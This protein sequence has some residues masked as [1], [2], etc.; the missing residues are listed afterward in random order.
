MLKKTISLILT[1]A[2]LISLLPSFP[3][4]TA[5]AATDFGQMNALDALGIDTSVVPEDYDPDSLDN[6]YGR[7][8]V[9]VNPVYELFVTGVAASGL[10]NTLYGHNKALSQSMHNFYNSQGVITSPTI[11]F[12]ALAATASASG[13]FVGEGVNG[14]AVGK[15]GQVVTVGV[16]ELSAYGGLYLYFTDPVTGAMSDDPKT[17]LNTDRIIGN[18]GKRMDEDFVDSPILMQNYLQITTGDFIGDGIDEVAVYVAEQDNSRVE[19]YKLQTTDTSDDDFYLNPGN[20]TKVWTHY[21]NESPFVSNMVSLT[22]GDFNRNGTDDL[23]LTWGYYYGPGENSGSQAVVLYGDNRHMFQQKRTIDLVYD[24]APIVRAS[25]AY[26][27]ITGDNVPDL[28]LGGQLHTDIAAGKLNTR[29]VASYTYDGFTDRFIPTAARNFDLFEKKNNQYVHAAMAGHGNKFY[30]SPASV[31]NITSVKM[32]GVGHA[33]HIYLDSL[34][35]EF[36]DDGLEIFQALDQNLSFN[37]NMTTPQKHYVEYGVAAADFTGDSKETIQ[38]M[39]YYPAVTVQ[40]TYKPYYWW[41]W[42]SITVT[43]D[44]PAELNL[45]GLYKTDSGMQAW[46]KENQAFSTSFCKLNTDEDTSLLRYTGVHYVTYSDPK[47]LAVLASPPYFA[48]LDNDE[49]SGSY[50]DSQ[51]SYRSSTGSGAGEVASHTLKAGAYVSFQHD[52]TVPVTG[53]KVGSIETE[54]SYTANLTWESAKSSMLEQSISYSTA[55]GS[56]AVAFYSIPMETYVYESFVPIIDEDTGLTEG[57]DIQL[58]SRNIPHTAAVRVLP[59]AT[60]ERIAADYAELPQISGNILTHTVGVPSTYPSSSA[61]FNKA[62]VYKGD[63][64]GV[65]YGGGSISQEITMTKEVEDSFTHSHAVDFKIG[66]GPGSFVFGRTAGYEYG[67][68]RVTVTTS[69][70]TYTGQVNN[71]PI[72]AEPYNYNYAWR[73]FSYEY[74]EGGWVLGPGLLPLFEGTRFPVVSYLVA[75]VSA[76]PRLPSD[77]QQDTAKTTDESITLK[78]SYSGP[79][80]GFQI[81]R[82]YEFPDGSGSYELGE[83]VKASEPIDVDPISGTRYYEYEDTGLHPYTDY[84]YQIQV[85]GISQPTHSIPSKIHRFRTKTDVGYP[86]LSLT[87]VSDGSLPMIYPDTEHTVSV[88]V[89]NIVDYTQPPK[90]QWQKLSESGWKNILGAINPDYTFRL[91]GLADEGQYRCRVNVIYGEYHISDYSEVFTLHYSKRTPEVR[92]FTVTDAHANNIPKIDVSIG[93]KHH[94]HY[95]RPS[96]IIVFDVVGADYRQSFAVSLETQSAADGEANASITLDHPLPEGAY[97]ITAFYSGSRVYQ[98]LITP[99]PIPYLSGTGSGYV[100]TLDSSYVYGD[101]IEPSVKRVVKEDGITIPTDITGDISYQVVRYWW[102]WDDDEGWL[103]NPTTVDGF[104]SGDSVTAYRAGD[105]FWLTASVNSEAVA[106]RQFSVAPKKVTIGIV[107]QHRMAGDET[108]VHPDDSILTV[109]PNTLA[110]QDSIA[111]LGL[112]VRAINTAGTEV[113]ISGETDPG[114]YEIVGVPGE[115]SAI[116]E[117]YHNYSITYQSGTYILTGPMFSV[118]G[119]AKPLNNKTVGTI[120]LLIPESVENWPVQYSSGTYLVFLASPNAGYNVKS[121]TIKDSESDAVI[122]TYGSRSTL[123]YSMRSQHIAV[124]VDFEVAQRRLNYRVIGE[125]TVEC[126]SSTVM[127]SGEVAME[128]AEFTFKATPAEGYHFTEWQLHEIGKTPTKPIGTPDVDGSSTCTITMGTDD[129]TLYAVF[130]RDSY[131]LTLQGDLQAGYWVDAD[132]GQEW[133][134][135]VSGNLIKGDTDVT[136]TP[137]PGFSVGSSAVWEQD[138]WSVS[139]DVDSDNQSYTFT[140]LADTVIAVQTEV[141]SFD[142]DLQVVGPGDTVNAVAVVLNGVPVDANNLTAIAGGSSLKFTAMPAYGYLFDKWIVND[143]IN[144]G[145]TLNVAALGGDLDVKAVFKDNAGYTVSVIH[146][147][148]GS[149]TY[150]LNDGEIT[151]ITSGGDIQVFAGDQVVI[152]ATPEINFMVEHWW[153]NDILKQTTVRTQTFQNIATD[154]NV[155]VVFGA[156][157]YSTVTYEAGPNGSIA[158]ATS[159]GV[160]FESGNNSIGNGSTLEFTAV[161]DTGMMVSEWRLN[162]E[163]V[164]NEYNQPLVDTTYCIPALS[165]TA[166]VEVTFREIITH[167]VQINNTNTTTTVAYIPE[168]AMVDEG[169]VHHGAAAVF[170]VTPGS[171]HAI[172][173][174][175]VAGNT[176]A[177][178]LNGFDSITKQEDGKWICVVNAVTAD[179]QVAVEAKQLYSITTT[180]IPVGGGSITC[181]ADSAIVGEIITVTAIPASASYAFDGWTVEPDTVEVSDSDA[182][183]TS[184]TMPESDV[185]VTADFKSISPGPGGGGMQQPEKT[186]LTVSS[187]SKTLQVPYTMQ[188]SRVVLMLD[189]SIMD[190]LLAHNSETDIIIDITGII[191]CSS[192]ELEIDGK[193]LIGDGNVSTLT[194]IGLGEVTI[195]S[196]ML[197]NFEVNQHSKVTVKIEL[198]SIT[199]SVELNSRVIEGRDLF[200]PIRVVYPYDKPMSNTTIIYDTK[201]GSILPFSLFDGKGNM[202]FLTSHFGT[203]EAKNNLKIFSDVAGH[204]ADDNIAFATAREL[205]VGTSTT[206]FSP[207]LPMTRAMFV[208]V[209]GRLLN[210]DEADYTGTVFSDV[211]VGQW[212]SPYVQWASQNGIVK[213]YGSGIFGPEDKITRE[214]MA[215]LILRFAEYANIELAVESS[216][217]VFDDKDK[218]SSWAAEYVSAAQRSSLIEGKSNKLFDPQGTATRAEVATILKRFIENTLK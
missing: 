16:G 213:G 113:T 209:M 47:V 58:M 37:K 114:S 112:E 170:T 98:S 152:T 22:A 95:Y 182:A 106:S 9:V 157:I 124:T 6:P 143:V 101:P 136:V 178:G 123:H 51:T 200:N 117:T 192:V 154:L 173:S 133:K 186:N 54:L 208:T 156:Q 177:D 49:L 43:E 70:N 214:Q 130:V 20:W 82:Y 13:N 132:I 67:S 174:V 217:I 64:A 28:I 26:G 85:V 73:V 56:D 7:D 63:P 175:S 146:G 91:A 199:I 46:R 10:Q 159:D 168:S 52:F 21:F 165:G 25:F 48:D 145:S 42:Q 129:T 205:F 94:N 125:G 127:K 128:G 185:F 88:V 83:L 151:T 160:S 18:T 89:N 12:D 71:M 153:I 45:L 148:R 24:T 162:G 87:G 131:Q 68:S 115:M 78:W 158:S 138:G 181:S 179:L 55:A 61:G 134:T 19:I 110:Y 36:G 163:I 201:T 76:P 116:S 184:F 171:D 102:E 195:S 150:S 216:G 147:L 172:A 75:G 206:E 189:D 118:T 164:T 14:D 3:L 57:Y 11:S 50:M 29:F 122:A 33:A 126:T 17:L 53:T 34:L 120:E 149:V 62:I 30:S 166:H 93:S 218:I 211:K 183:S 4:P 60:Y 167:L 69:G 204:W 86:D 196:E 77:F 210:I 65:N 194:V 23:A 8:N 39:Q 104:V 176:G 108:L 107:N 142:I 35:I 144:Y 38:L 119:S 111:D 99:E 74:S 197:K 105:E 212:Y 100:L 139:A 188:D 15:T 27:D 41:W 198:G 161:P 103:W 155:E 66:A 169:E 59:L 135:V 2:M 5:A 84:A 72:E 92:S 191:G 80:A 97:E 81:Y 1:M 109:P 202:K 31:A 44:Y 140:M 90:Y 79:A 32:N 141:G 96:G 190:E 137:K 215:V 207:N 121:W 40:W 193:W 187:G 180:T 203:F